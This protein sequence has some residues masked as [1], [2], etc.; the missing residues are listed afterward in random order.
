MAA[1]ET[2][3]QIPSSLRE[4]ASDSAG[5]ST[6]G[7][8]REILKLLS[9]AVSTIKI[10]PSIHSSLRTLIDELA[11]R[12]KSFLDEHGAIEI[13]IQER[14]FT[15]AGQPVFR[16]DHAV[17]SL[18]F[19]FF[20]DGMQILFFYPGLDRQEIVEF[21]EIIRRESFLP[22]D[23]ADIVNALW[24]R[25]FGNIQYFAP[26]DFLESRVL[27][28]R[29]EWAQQMHVVESE[30]IVLSEVEIKVDKDNFG[31]GRI[32]L[33]AE[34]RV[35]AARSDSAS[36]EI[37]EV[38]SETDGQAGDQTGAESPLHKASLNE[39][40]I[41][42]IE[43]MIRSNRELP[44]HQEY[45]DL[46]IEILFLE[47]SLPMFRSTTSV[48]EQHFMD[49]VQRGEYDQARLLVERARLLRA[50]FEQEKNTSKAAR[51]D[52]FVKFA[53]DEKILAVIKA[54]ILSQ[55][56]A[57]PEGL[58]DFLR[59][60]GPSV[61]Q[62]LAEVYE[63]IE[64][65]DFRRLVLEYIR[66]MA[67]EDFRT[68]INLA[69]DH[70]PLLTREIIG[71]LFDLKNKKSIP[72]FANFLNYTTKDIKMEAIDALGAF[73]DETAN[74]IILEFMKDPDP[75]IRT[76]AALRLRYLGDLG[77]LKQMILQAQSREFRKKSPI[78]Q[79]AI[80]TYL[81]KSR[82]DEACRYLKSVLMTPSL[83]SPKVTSLR[84]LAVDA[85]ELMSTDGARA[86]LDRGSRLWNFKI[87]RACLQALEAVAARSA[88]SEG[89]DHLPPEADAP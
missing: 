48:L 72:F 78:E 37:R 84:L 88:R 74:K 16:D 53:R 67:R 70:R 21:L 7:K 17:R 40:E 6:T 38:E 18:P 83:L 46:L 13:G 87:R 69:N 14:S 68:A 65:L 64:N 49:M 43:F 24:E 33:D 63:R 52:E 51:L 59:T 27:K 9:Q 10:Y 41:E 57:S 79:K 12:F 36:T 8:I 20:K 28:E 5:R 76:R 11:G 22:P 44:P 50:H 61:L 3:N 81:G 89:Q 25:E 1:E 77:R 39:P 29:D 34:D 30:G 86:A 23:E 75:E 85:L 60:F 19:F 35:P 26:D 73:E 80:F 31:R 45:I 32:E 2:K 55:D 66:A 58:M 54:Q 47:D 71:L 42:R 56:I 82:T 15:Y 4:Q 62:V